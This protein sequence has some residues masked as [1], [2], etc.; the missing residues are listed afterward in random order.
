DAPD[1]KQVEFAIP[2]DQVLHKRHQV[3]TLLQEVQLLEK[4]IR[5][6]MVPTVTIRAIKGHS[7][8]LKAEGKALSASNKHL[9]ETTQDLQ[10]TICSLLNK[11][12]VTNE[13]Q[14]EVWKKIWDT[15]RN[16]DK[17]GY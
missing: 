7:K 15:L 10:S 17:T 16:E 5:E 12:K 11:A 3:L 2:S 1:V 9:R 14:V 4:E 6:N 13:M 8:E